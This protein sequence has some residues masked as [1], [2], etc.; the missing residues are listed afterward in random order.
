MRGSWGCAVVLGV[1]A[2][3]VQIPEE[4]IDVYDVAGDYRAIAQCTFLAARPKGFMQVMND[5]SSL[6]RVELVHTAGGVR[7]LGKMDFVSK[8]PGRTEVRVNMPRTVYG[9]GFWNGRL[10]PIVTGCSE[11]G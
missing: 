8:A 10:R 1:V 3:C 11:T 6:G 5:Y 4:P 9:P 7:P 2:G